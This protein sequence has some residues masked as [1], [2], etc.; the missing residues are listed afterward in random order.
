MKKKKLLTLFGSICLV[1]VLVALLIPACAKEAPAPAPAPPAPAP[2]APT[3]TEPEK[4]FK[5]KMQN[6]YN[7]SPGVLGYKTNWA[8]WVDFVDEVKERTNGGVDIKMYPANAL[9]KVLEAPEALQK[10]A[11]EMMGSSGSYWT[12]LVPEALLEWGPPYC[13]KN[14]EQGAKLHL[15][16]DFDEIYRQACAEH[17]NAYLLGLTSASSYGFMT[18]SP[19]HGFADMK[20]MKIRATGQ[21]ALV[22]KACG[23][24]S[25]NIPGAECY[26]ALQRGTVDGTCFPAYVGIIYKWFEVVKYLSFPCPWAV[27]TCHTVINMD[28]WNSLPEAYQKILQEE[29]KK[30]QEYMFYE[31]GPALERLAREEGR[32]QYGVESIV[33]SEEE[34][35]KFREAVYPLW[36]EWGAKSEYAAKMLEISKEVAGIK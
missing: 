17:A 9:F 23:A 35:D 19:I 2:V 25:V 8:A 34:L 6:A 3:P 12:N 36:E 11:I 13:L 10:G 21:P 27:S 28:A 22:T 7:P 15:E 26:T 31:S 30:M 16:T 33:L 32:K 20:G 1:L 24:S 18:R 29:M 4:V 5:W 14:S